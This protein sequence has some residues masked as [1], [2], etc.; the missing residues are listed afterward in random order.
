L[1]ALNW[2]TQRSLMDHPLMSTYPI[3]FPPVL[4]GTAPGPSTE[5][6]SQVLLW[7]LSPSGSVHMP[8]LPGRTA[9]NRLYLCSVFARLQLPQCPPTP[10]DRWCPAC[11]R[12]VNA[13]LDWRPLS[14]QDTLLLDAN[15]RDTTTRSCTQD[16]VHQKLA[17]LANPK[18]HY[19]VH[20]NPPLEPILSQ[21]NPVLFLPFH[22][23]KISFKPG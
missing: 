15:C 1:A 22:C 2:R 19:R 14:A 20:K 13:A 23:F 5:G 3:H 8:L 11:I 9:A 12:N 4:S 16:S 21:M 7:G 17:Q 18:V 6:L 10:Q